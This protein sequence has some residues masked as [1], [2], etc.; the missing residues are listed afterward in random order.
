MRLDSWRYSHLFYPFFQRGQVHAYLNSARSDEISVLAGWN[1]NTNTYRQ[2]YFLRV[3]TRLKISPTEMS[4]LVEL[5]RI[6]D[7][8]D[9]QYMTCDHNCVII[10]GLIS[11]NSKSVCKDV[12]N[13][14]RSSGDG[15]GG[16]V[17]SWNRDDKGVVADWP[18]ARLTVCRKD[19][20]PREVEEEIVNWLT[21]GDNGRC[22][23][24][25]VGVAGV[26]LRVGGVKGCFFLAEKGRRKDHSDS[27]C[28]ASN[29][30][31]MG[32]YV[33]I[34]E[35]RSSSMRRSA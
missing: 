33:S 20:N 24:G 3:I 9:V 23:L 21:A 22:G 7:L 27:N 4:I 12:R 6:D 26:R 28:T 1:Y 25:L 17:G 14:V 11:D 13:E 5:A 2:M 34:V 30:E 29:S 16:D 8:H 32:V 15:G 35:S 10:T 19:E 18:L 31:G